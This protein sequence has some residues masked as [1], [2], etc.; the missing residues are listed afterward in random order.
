[1]RD[2]F[3]KLWIHGIF[4]TEPNK[5]YIH[6]ELANVLYL[7]IEKKFIEQGCNLAAIGG[8]EDHIHFLFSQNPLLSLHETMT[9]IQGITERWYQLRDVESDYSKFKWAHG[10]CAYSVS[11][12][13]LEKTQSFIDNQ[14]F[15]HKKMSLLNEISLL[16]KLH[17]VDVQDEEMEN[18]MKVFEPRFS[19]KHIGDEWL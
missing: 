11:E 13:G 6:P 9:F 16:N 7:E 1:M 12:S 14:V 5:A 15:I 10:Y 17:N 18:E 4:Q 19:F 2:T 3:F 8:Q